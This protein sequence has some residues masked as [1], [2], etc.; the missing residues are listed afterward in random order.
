MKY[1]NLIKTIIFIF[2]ITLVSSCVK[3]VK[4]DSRLTPVENPFEFQ[5]EYYPITVGNYWR[6]TSVGPFRDTN[7]ALNGFFEHRIIEFKYEDIYFGD[8]LVRIPVFKKENKFFKLHEKEYD[9]VKYSYLIKTKEGV[10]E[11]IKPP[12]E[13]KIAA[14]LFIPTDSSYDELSFAVTGRNIVRGVELKTK[15]WDMNTVRINY[16]DEYNIGGMYYSKNRGHV[17]TKFYKKPYMKNERPFVEFV[18]SKIQIE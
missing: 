14:H 16:D 6:M 13:N 10:I 12:S 15:L 4:L 1:S 8:S 17:Y 7:Y 18:L 5:N 2:G 3:Y 9:E 11:C